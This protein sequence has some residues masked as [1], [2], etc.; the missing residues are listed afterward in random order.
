MNGVD[1]RAD[2]HPLSNGASSNES[3]LGQPT[4]QAQTIS[5]GMVSPIRSFGP[6]A[7]I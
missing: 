1:Q 3:A 2:V 5:A 4:A 6:V 7:D